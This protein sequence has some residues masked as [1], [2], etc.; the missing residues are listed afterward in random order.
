MMA[1]RGVDVDL[2]LQSCLTTAVDG[3]Q[4]HAPR[5]F[6]P[7]KELWYLLNRRLSRLQSWSARF[8]AEI[9]LLSLPGFE[10]RIVH[11]VA[12]SLY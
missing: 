10:P 6:T 5:R 3:G 2:Q 4:L 8:G 7:W 11:P 12:L 1:Y 9:N